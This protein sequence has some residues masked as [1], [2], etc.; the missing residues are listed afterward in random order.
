MTIRRN[1]ILPTIL[2]TGTRLFRDLNVKL[3]KENEL[4]KLKNEIDLCQTILFNQQSGAR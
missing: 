2:K 4:K 1:F 3:S